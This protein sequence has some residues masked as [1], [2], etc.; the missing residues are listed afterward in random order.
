[1]DSKVYRYPK[2]TAR[3]CLLRRSLGTFMSHDPKLLFEARE[4]KPYADTV[5][6]AALQPGTLYFSVTFVDV[7]ALVPCLQPLVF[8]GRDLRADESGYLYF[9]D[10]ESY[11]RGITFGEATSESP[12]PRFLR[13]P[14]KAMFNVHDFQGALD[15]LL[16]CSLRRSGLAPR[17]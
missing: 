1:M 7:E 14:E 16:V 8:L 17:P 11:Q 12:P 3:S 9:Q 15:E 10:F 13:Y 6:Q 4:L 2:P 5:P